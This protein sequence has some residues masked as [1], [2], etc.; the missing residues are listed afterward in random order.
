MQL[1][2]EIIQINNFD[3]YLKDIHFQVRYCL[4]CKETNL[5]I[6]LEKE[7]IQVIPSTIVIEDKE[8]DRLAWYK[9]ILRIML[10][11]CLKKQKRYLDQ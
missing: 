3:R 1:W 8:I 4:E 2:N 7:L 9:K 11:K 6:M 10:L 5:L